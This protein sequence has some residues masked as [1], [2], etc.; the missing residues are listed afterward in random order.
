MSGSV[1]IAA[2]VVSVAILM[3]AAVTALTS[4]SVLKRIVAVLTAL[5][6][7]A[8][9]AG[10][11]S[12]AA[13]TLGAIALMFAYGVFGVAILVRLQE[14]YG[15]SDAGDIDMADDQGEAGDA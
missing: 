10:V 3:G 6:A 4:A 1:E 14:S 7:A 15:G 11:L 13:A 9:A 2:L 12:A 8:L 5:I